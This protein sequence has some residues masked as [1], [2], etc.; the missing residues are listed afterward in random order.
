MTLIFTKLR[1]RE[2]LRNQSVVRLETFRERTTKMKIRT[3]K[4]KALLRPFQRASINNMNLLFI[5]FFLFL[6]HSF[7]IF[8]LFF[9]N[10]R[11]SFSFLHFLNLHLNYVVYHTICLTSNAG[12]SNN[13][14]VINSETDLLTKETILHMLKQRVETTAMF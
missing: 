8:S 10:C 7:K 5:D 2:F 9:A 12:F 4:K 13:E 3:Q 14:L 1:F 11:K 6:V